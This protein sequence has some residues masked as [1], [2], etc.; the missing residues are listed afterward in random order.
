M[1]GGR[2]GEGKVLHKVLYREAL[3]CPLPFL[4]TILTEK[5][6]L[7][8]TFLKTLNPFCKQWNEVEG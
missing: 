1:G 5:V 4:Y 3:I 8:H 2:E 6:P 7:S